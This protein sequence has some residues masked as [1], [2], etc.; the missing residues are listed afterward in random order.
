MRA[1]KSILLAAALSAVTFLQ[2]SAQERLSIDA[3]GRPVRVQVGINFFMP[4]I[5]SDANDEAAR[6]RENARKIVYEMA[7]KECGVLQSVLASSCRL[8]ALNVNVNRQAGQ[9]LGGFLVNGSMT[10]S[11]TLK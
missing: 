4:G 1:A 9:Q 7:A 8:E 11:I 2:S 5:A 3:S 6:V 10:Y